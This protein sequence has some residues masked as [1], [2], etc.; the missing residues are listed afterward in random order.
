MNKTIRVVIKGR[1]Q[2]VNYRAWTVETA[3]S[4]GLKGWV[5]NRKDESVE[6]VF[7]GEEAVVDIMIERCKKGPM[8]ARVDSMEM[9]A[10]D[11]IPEG[12]ERKAT[13]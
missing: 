5:R 10:C 8:V 4:L 2:G 12:F 11:E 3:S 13:V 1:V 7:S 6:A 9:F